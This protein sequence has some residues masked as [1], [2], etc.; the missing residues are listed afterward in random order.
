MLT[1]GSNE[2]LYTGQF[3]YAGK[4]AALT[5]GNILPLGQVPEGTVVSNVEEKIGDR[6]AVRDPMVQ[7]YLLDML[8]YKNFSSA[9]LP[10]T[11][12]LSL[13]TTQTRARHVSSSHPA[14]RRLSRAL[15]VAWSVSWPEAVG[16]TSLCSVRSPRITLM[17]AIGR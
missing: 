16:L 9:V 13:D 8:A 4:N 5:V 3:I 12:L 2:G 15:S 10:E 6:G 14:Q 1:I 7:E 17:V 11:T